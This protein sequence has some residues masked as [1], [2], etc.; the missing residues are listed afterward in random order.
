MTFEE[1][2][3]AEGSGL[4]RLSYALCG[5]RGRAEDACQEALARLYVRWRS[6]EDPLP[7]ARRMVVNATRD[8]WR[9]TGRRETVG[10]P[11]IHE[12]TTSTAD[13]ISAYDDRVELL[14]AL[15]G[16]PHGQRAV[17]ALRYWHQLSEVETA[18]TLGV[19]VGTVKSQAHRGLN[20]LRA[21]LP[22]SEGRP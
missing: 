5:D 11:A 3:R 14:Q 2:A 16:L 10:L 21:L 15:R 22:V 18:K 12:P 8:G 1:F 20:R 4:L 19:S 9:R 6:V 13:P 7:Y 17:L